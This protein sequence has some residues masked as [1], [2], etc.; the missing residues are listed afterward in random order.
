VR[1]SLA[2]VELVEADTLLPGHGDPWRGTMSDA[3]ARARESD[4]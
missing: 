4:T 2:E 3:V 1:A